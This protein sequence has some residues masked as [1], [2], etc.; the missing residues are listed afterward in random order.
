MIGYAGPWRTS[1]EWWR[2]ES[3]ARDEWD[4]ALHTGALYRISRE[5]YTGPGKLKYAEL[6]VPDSWQ[7]SQPAPPP[8]VSAPV[9]SVARPWVAASS[10]PPTSSTYTPSK[11]QHDLTSRWFINGNYD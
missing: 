4:I 1:G 10:P 8:E 9:F 2:D 5:I 7:Y 3:W 11:K 6:P